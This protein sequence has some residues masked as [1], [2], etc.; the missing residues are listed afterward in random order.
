MRIIKV[1][2]SYDQLIIKKMKKVSTRAHGIMDYIS[3]LIIIASPWLLNFADGTIA[4]WLPVVIGVVLL[5]SSI[6]TNYESGLVRIIP[7]PVHLWL[8]IFVGA[9]LLVS[10]W[11][12]GFA[13]RIYLPH[14]IFGLFEMGAGF[15]TQTHPSYRTMAH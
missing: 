7:M 13:D 9:L 2:L 8:D 3:G 1:T 5:L 6:M 15:M 12:F 10:P 11:V 14:V 4:Q